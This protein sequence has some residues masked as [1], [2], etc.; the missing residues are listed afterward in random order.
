M[1]HKILPRSFINMNYR[2][3]SH[4]LMS[5]SPSK[6]PQQSFNAEVTGLSADWKV[7]NRYKNKKKGLYI[8]CCIKSHKVAFLQGLQGHQSCCPHSTRK[9]FSS[10]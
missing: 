4:V 2:D 9:L 8:S 6:S 3:I 5:N 1:L 7:D 10:G